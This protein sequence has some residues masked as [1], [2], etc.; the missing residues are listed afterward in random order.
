MHIGA[1]LQRRGR[2]QGVG[3]KMR[4]SLEYKCSGAWLP[5]TLKK[6]TIPYAHI[7]LCTQQAE[8]WGGTSIF[9]SHPLHIFRGPV[10]RPSAI[11][12][13]GYAA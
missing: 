1:R 9:M 3:Y 6:K 13:H 8:T 4:F 12:A 7:L 10:L 11:D 2:H 5:P